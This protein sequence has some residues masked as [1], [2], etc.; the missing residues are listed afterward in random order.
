MYKD[1][2]WFESNELMPKL[3]LNFWSWESND[4]E[5]I[6]TWGQVYGIFKSIE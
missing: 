5:N 1:E 4:G 3:T 2:I 6:Q